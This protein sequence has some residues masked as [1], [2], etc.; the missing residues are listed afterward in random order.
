MSKFLAFIGIVAF[1]GT[2]IYFIYKEGENKGKIEEV[3]KSQ[4]IEI[5]IKNEAIVE[6]NEI[7]K[8]KESRKFNTSNSNLE[9]LYK[10]RCKN[11]KNERFLP[12]L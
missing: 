1:V 2:I 12:A 7:I 8:R 4:E 9:W 3:K 6:Q 5:K 11:C 10:N